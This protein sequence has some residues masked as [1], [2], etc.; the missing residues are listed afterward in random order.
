MTR[1]ILLSGLYIENCS[2]EKLPR[3]GTLQNKTF[4]LICN[5]YFKFLVATLKKVDNSFFL[6]IIVSL[7]NY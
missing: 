5:V 4:Q 7:I 2:I 6:L 3:D 1:C